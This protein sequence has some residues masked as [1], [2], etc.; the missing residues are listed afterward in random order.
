MLM[1]HLGHRPNIHPSASIAPTAVVSGEVTVGPGSR[2]LAGAVLT[3]DGG[4]VEVGRRCVVMEQAVLRGTPRH[5]LRLANHVMVGPHAHLTGCDVQDA[6]FIAT[7]AMVFNGARLG[8]VSM[9]GLG[10][11]V[12]IGCNLPAESV[13]PIGWV[14]V[15][16]PAEVH[17][18]H[19]ANKIWAGLAA[20][21]GF[22]H[23]V[24]GVETGLSRE[25]T[26][27]AALDRYTDALAEHA[28]DRDLGDEA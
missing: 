3:A 27:I 4:P 5:P 6:V 7:N 20:T 25:E 22:M 23:Y 24:F 16:D 2:V 26:M 21:G 14:A 8:R 13:V 18:P 11:A 9:V 12:H 28:R 17:P 1:E 15:G 19:E 10:G